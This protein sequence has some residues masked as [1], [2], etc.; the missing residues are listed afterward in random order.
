M[1][2][3]TS[4]APVK[5]AHTSDGAARSNLM[6]REEFIRRVLHSGE[7]TQI[8]QHLAL[9]V[10]LLAEGRNQLQLSVRDLEKITGWS[11]PTIRAHIDEL[12]IFMRVTFGGG[13]AKALFEL[14]GVIEDALANAVVAGSRA[15]KAATKFAT[16]QPATTVIAKE[17][18]KTDVAA[19][20][21]ATNV[22]ANQVTTNDF[23]ANQPAANGFVASHLATSLLASVVATTPVMASKV[24]TTPSVVASQPATSPS[25]KERRENL[26]LFKNEH[27]RGAGPIQLN[28]SVI[29]G[30]D[31]VIDLNAVDLAA[32][33]VGMP[34][35]RARAIAEICARDWAANGT[36]PAY[37]MA[38][39]SRAIK[40]DLN[41]D[42]VQSLRLEAAKASGKSKSKPRAL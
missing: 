19:K 11:R 25:Y 35:E 13:R 37:P 12:D 7:I 41:H 40:N 15:F 5:H 16:N 22:V 23:V 42:Q 4:G 9:V 8:A 28:G 39:I 33:S 1:I 3:I 18:A 32:G 10:F 21:A 27:E 38:M 29:S 20:E 6:T 34:K 36:K 14:Q 31:F 26:S 2:N 30:P 24:A 17:A